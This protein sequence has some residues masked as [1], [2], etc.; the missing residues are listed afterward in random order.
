MACARRYGFS[1]AWAHVFLPDGPGDAPQS[2]IPSLLA[3]LVAGTPIIVIDGSQ[4]RDFVYVT[5][6]R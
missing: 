2:L 6:N 5:D 4:V 1:A 3:A